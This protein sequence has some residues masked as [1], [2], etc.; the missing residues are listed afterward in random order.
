MILECFYDI[1][2]SPESATRMAQMVS[3][4]YKADLTINNDMDEFSWPESGTIRNAL[5]LAPLGFGVV[6]YSR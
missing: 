5:I 3:T 1:A 2:E 6:K 4:H